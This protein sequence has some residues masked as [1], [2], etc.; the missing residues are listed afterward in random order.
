[1]LKQRDCHSSEQSVRRAASRHRRDT[2]LAVRR[3]S[4]RSSSRST[5]CSKRCEGSG[6]SCD[7]LRTS[8]GSAAMLA[9]AEEEAA[10]PAGGSCTAASS[11]SGTG[12]GS[13]GGVKIGSHWAAC[14]SSGVRSASTPKRWRTPSTSSCRM[15]CAM[16]L[17]I[18]E[19]STSHPRKSAP[20]ARP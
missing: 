6:C 11:S 3:S 8:G 2:P 10:V 5:P 14:S 19:R 1:M 13:S 16:R 9:L 12:T 4:T 15:S 17:Q 18:S 7:R 20:S